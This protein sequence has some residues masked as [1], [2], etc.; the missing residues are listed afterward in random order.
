MDD[1]GGGDMGGGGRE[2][3]WKE[4]GDRP[5]TEPRR[6]SGSERAAAGLLGFRLWSKAEEKSVRGAETNWA[7]GPPPQLPE[8]PPSKPPR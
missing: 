5:T 8:P 7:I 6:G 3:T 4:G 2:G 1:M